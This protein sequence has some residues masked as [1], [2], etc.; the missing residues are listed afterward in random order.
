MTRLQP[1]K[2]GDAQYLR[3]QPVSNAVQMNQ[4]IDEILEDDFD[5]ST[6]AKDEIKKMD[7]SLKIADGDHLAGD[8]DS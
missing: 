4:D 6:T 8:E 7:S 1:V 5:D 3:A 2:Q